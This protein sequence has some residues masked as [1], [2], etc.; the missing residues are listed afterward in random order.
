[1]PARQRLGLEDDHGSEQWREQPLAPD[2]EQSM[3]RAQSGACWRGPLQDSKL[4]AKKSNLGLASRTR[5]EVTVREGPRE[6]LH[7]VDLAGT[8]L[9]YRCISVSRDEVSGSHSRRRRMDSA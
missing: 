5:S 8:M 7:K 4:L 9:A 6:R 3:W 2:Q 1:M